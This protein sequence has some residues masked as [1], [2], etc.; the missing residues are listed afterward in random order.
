MPEQH[1]ISE[2]ILKKTFP[3]YFK[4]DR[5]LTFVKCGPSLEK[6]TS[7]IRNQV[8]S[9]WVKLVQP[10]LS[11]V[12]FEALSQLENQQVLLVLQL[13]KG[14]ILYKA[15]LI[16]LPT[17]DQLLFLGAPNFHHSNELEV[18]GVTLDD[19][20]VSDPAI[21]TLQLLQLNEQVNSDL[22][23]VNDR[24]IQKEQLYRS[25][26]NQATELIFTTDL[27]GNFKFMNEI[28][29]ELTHIE[30]EKR[31]NFV[32]LVNSKFVQ[33]IKTK[34]T[35]LL[36]KQITSFYVE[37][38]L[39]SD[40]NLWIGQNVTAVEEGDVFIGF[41]AVGRNVTE[42]KAYEKE[43]LKEKDKAEHA[44][45]SKSRFLANMSHE[46]RTPLNGIMGLTELLLKNAADPKQEQYLKAIASSSETL[47]V[48]I[49]DVLDISK[50][51]AGKIKINNKPFSPQTAVSQ[52]VDMMYLKAAEK[53][54]DLKYNSS[55][56]LPEMLLGDEARLN[57]ILYNIIGNAIKF[58][59]KGTVTVDVFSMAESGQ[60]TELHIA[61]SDTG[62][63]IPKEEIRTIFSAFS[64]LE[65]ANETQKG[66]GLGLTISRR[67]IELQGGTI[68]VS[69]V[70][71]QGTTFEI[72]IPFQ[73]PNQ[74]EMRP[75]EDQGA[76]EGLK[77]L[78]VLLV[79]D[80]PINQMVTA[81]VIVD[82]GAEIKV[83][84]N[85][86]QALEDIKS[87]QP[88]VVL[89][90]MQMPIMDGYDAIRAIRSDETTTHLPVIA[91]TAHV[92][93]GEIEKCLSAGADDYISK[94]FK[95]EDL[96]KKVIRLV[97][98]Q[99]SAKRSEGLF[100]KSRASNE[101]VSC[102]D[103]EPLIQM[104]QG[105]Q[106]LVASILD[107][108]PNQINIDMQEIE[109]K[110]LNREYETARGLVHR[111]KPNLKMVCTKAF[112]ALLDQL[113]ATCGNVKSRSELKE[114]FEKVRLGKD[115][116]VNGVRKE[117]SQIKRPITRPSKLGELQA[118]H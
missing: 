66:T 62:V 76:F 17:E 89:M 53:G 112:A 100:E 107:K 7:N 93:E 12:S 64:Q 42:R 108:L 43:L 32:K 60:D 27:E 117:L 63:G 13:P 70:V 69:S 50:I 1:Q 84:G 116:I 85:G 105:K 67:L 37:F 110:I 74:L 15:Q 59:R 20:A 2:G 81:D 11:E 80:N 44:A 90:D 22:N 114:L 57:Q 14:K 54:I 94:P 71:N 88:E 111:C 16:Y 78:R 38:Q 8:F 23:E 106:S 45:K 51:E 33:E 6:I 34:C 48:V 72:M 82:F 102:F 30:D 29:K 46:I 49:N 73:I 21:D 68:N 75:D 83:A 113:E 31:Y 52:V 26:V 118:P 25:I 98:N 65:Q 41:Q 95:A 36:K 87:Y 28:C 91:F 10:K 104:T 18:H 77:G 24:L 40:D 58:T 115:Q 56:S 109:L 86:K 96:K 103:L 39:K 99:K 47:M 5:S 19:F 92:T 97:T 79:E 55:K 4:L 9:D 3:F 101:V 61:I 35:A